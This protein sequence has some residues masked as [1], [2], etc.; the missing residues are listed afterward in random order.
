MAANEAMVPGCEAN[1]DNF[2]RGS[3]LESVLS[4]DERRDF[5]I[6]VQKYVQ[7]EKIR[8]QYDLGFR[9]GIAGFLM[10]PNN[11]AYLEKLKRRNP[12]RSLVECSC[13]N[14][15]DCKVQKPELR[16][17]YR[18]HWYFMG[19]EK[20]AEVDEI[21]AIVDFNEHYLNR[22]A[23]LFRTVYDVSLCTNGL[24]C[25]RAEK[26]ILALLEEIELCSPVTWMNQVHGGNISD[27]NVEV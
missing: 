21:T 17:A 11:R 15:A 23:E 14:N 2:L 8:R 22:W 16:S 13:D 24:H 12:G 10:D 20:K 25:S 7:S 18:D 26:H 5:F 4:P 27:I 3:L 9:E 19:I 6:E 1:A